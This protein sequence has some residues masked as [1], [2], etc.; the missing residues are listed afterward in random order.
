[1]K[2]DKMS[3]LP[4]L[5]SIHSGWASLF[6]SSPF[7]LPSFPLL[8]KGGWQQHKMVAS[9]CAFHVA[10]AVGVTGQAEAS[11]I[12]SAWLLLWTSWMVAMEDQ[13]RAHETPAVAN[14]SISISNQEK[15]Q[16]PLREN[17][18]L[19]NGNFAVYWHLLISDRTSHHYS[20]LFYSLQTNLIQKTAFTDIIFI[21][22]IFSL[23]CNFNLIYK[24]FI[25][26]LQNI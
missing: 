15:D 12:S 8:L 21:I 1:M 23:C 2:V 22:H 16:P 25:Y 26:D 17:C 10:A 11:A 4:S 13:D 18:S 6:P 19:M 9:K 24:I 14:K 7:H 3:L 20:G 5:S